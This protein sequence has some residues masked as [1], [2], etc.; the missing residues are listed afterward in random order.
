MGYT[1]YWNA[2]N[3]KELSSRDIASFV[4]A[5][6]RAAEIAKVKYGLEIAG[7]DGTGEPVIR[8]DLISLNGLE[9]KHEDGESFRLLTG[10]TGFDFTKTVELPYDKLVGAILLLAEHYGIVT[11]VSSDGP[12]EEEAVYYIYLM[13]LYGEENDL[14]QRYHLN[15]EEETTLARAK[16]VIEVEKTLLKLKGTNHD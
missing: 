11:K 15:D 10:K 13:A 14:S 7:W 4:K 5:A 16:A 6:Q 8:T 1:R 3:I 12:N 9:A 2:L